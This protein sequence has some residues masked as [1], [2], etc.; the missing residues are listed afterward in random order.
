MSQGEEHFKIL[1][2]LFDAPIPESVQQ[3]L[4]CGAPKVAGGLALLGLPIG[5]DLNN[6]WGATQY[7]RTCRPD[8]DPQFLVIRLV[9]DRVMCID[10]R[11]QSDKE[12]QMVEI[13]CDSTINPE[14]I[15]VSFEAFLRRT[16]FEDDQTKRIFD[17]VDYL[18]E[19]YKYTYDHVAGGKLP[20]AH[21]WRVVRSCVHDRVVG[22]AALRQNDQTDST[23]IDLF[24][25]ADHPLYTAGHGIKSL[26]ALVLSDAYKAC[27]SMRLIFKSV[28]GIRTANVPQDITVF[29]RSCGINFAQQR[30][31][32]IEHE[33]GASLFA[34]AVGLSAKTISAIRSKGGLSLESI[35]YLV[36]T[37]IWT[38]EE[39]DWLMAECPSP[40]VV[41]FGLKDARDWVSYTEVVSWARAATLASTFRAALNEGGDE[42]IEAT[43]MEVI[44]GC[45]RF[46]VARSL[47]VPWSMLGRLNPNDSIAVLPRPRMPLPFEPSLL[48]QDARKLASAV[49][50]ATLRIIIQ[51]QESASV[52]AE[53]VKYQLDEFGVHLVASPYLLA[54]IDSL[55]ESKFERS[56]RVRQS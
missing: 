13:A 44:G 27:S 4:I 39:I 24:E 29:A 9:E 42:G 56:R 36:A 53:T 21:Q 34:A 47:V 2:T 50:N 52:S 15:D 28:H 20:R 12:S 7:L 46:Q 16:A 38:L 37:R 31:D 14:K 1:Q 54:D 48:A 55:V 49:P 45:F 26:L 43:A 35:S 33:D 3:W 8:L 5:P 22:I 23:E 6:A 32:T 18:L 25:V 41:L 10:L 30:S 19:R 11:T 17:R 40:H 51:S